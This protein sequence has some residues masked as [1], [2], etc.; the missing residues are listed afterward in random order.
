MGLALG[1]KKKK[2]RGGQNSQ[3]KGVRGETLPP[4]QN[5][6][7]PNKRVGWSLSTRKKNTRGSKIMVRGGGEG[8]GKVWG[9]AS[10]PT[11]KMVWRG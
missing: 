8:G 6:L 11:T 7:G 10:E 9:E 3:I 5:I 4:T 1:Q 2:R